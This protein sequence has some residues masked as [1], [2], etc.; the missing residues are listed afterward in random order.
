MTKLTSF[1]RRSFLAGTAAATGAL[2]MPP[3]ATAASKKVRIGF[4]SP[5]SGPRASFGTSDQWMVDSI[6]KQLE[7]GLNSGGSTH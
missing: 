3:I 5:L 7:G 2:A 1:S 4:I 6:R